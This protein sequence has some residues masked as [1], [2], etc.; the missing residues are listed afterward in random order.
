MWPIRRNVIGAY[1]P[2]G[3]VRNETGTKMPGPGS[4]LKRQCGAVEG[5]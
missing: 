2:S 3:E 1:G 4:P 5:F